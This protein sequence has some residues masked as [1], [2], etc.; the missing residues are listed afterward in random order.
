MQAQS[1]CNMC[2]RFFESNGWST[3]C[4]MCQKQ[5]EEEYCKI[6][7]YLYIHPGA[8]VFEVSVVLEISIYKIKRFLKEGRL[9]II[10]KNNTFLKC[11]DCGKSVC[12]GKYC[13][14]CI[15][16]NAHDFKSIYNVSST[17]NSTNKVNFITNK[18][19]NK[20]VAVR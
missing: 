6:R 11:E 19:T 18:G 12:S 14:E 4:P 15:K 8:K 9:E 2:G 10:E 5:L 3:F 16:K 13:D 17:K 7:E 20:K 1:N